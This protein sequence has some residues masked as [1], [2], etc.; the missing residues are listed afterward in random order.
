MLFLHSTSFAGNGQAR[1]NDLD[2]DFPRCAPVLRIGAVVALAG[3][4]L[5]LIDSDNDGRAASITLGC[6]VAVG[7]RFDAFA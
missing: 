1:S 2:N 7:Q 4:L 6:T 3:D 5:G